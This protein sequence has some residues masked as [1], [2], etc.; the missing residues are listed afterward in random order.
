[1]Q[2]PSGWKSTHTHT[3]VHTNNHTLTIYTKKLRVT[4][5]GAHYKRMSD[6]A[7]MNFNVRGNDLLEHINEQFLSL[8][9]TDKENK[10]FIKRHFNYIAF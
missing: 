2:S 8:S 10:L 9:V 3:H 5:T 1:M 7:E 6:T 4:C